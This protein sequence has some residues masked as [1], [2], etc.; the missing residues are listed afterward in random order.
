[1]SSITVATATAKTDAAAAP[2]VVSTT[3]T[4]AT[5]KWTNPATT[6]AASFQVWSTT[7]AGL[8]SKQS[9]ADITVAAGGVQTFTLTGL[10][11]GST[12]TVLLKRYEFSGYVA[13]GS[14][15]VSTLTAALQLSAGTNS[16]LAR[17]PSTDASSTFTVRFTGANIETT[18]IP[19][20]TIEAGMRSATLSNIAAGTY[21]ASLIVTESGTDTV[22]DTGSVAISATATAPV[23][24]TN[25]LCSRCLVEWGGNSSS[26]YRLVD[27]RAKVIM[28][29]DTQGPLRA[30][31]ITGL[32]PGTQ[33]TFILQ[34]KSPDG[35]YVD[36][37]TASLTTA[38]STLTVG[39][40][41]STG[42]KIEW[43]AAYSGA[44]YQL[45]YRSDSGAA[46]TRTLSSLSYTLTGLAPNTLY[47]VSLGVV[48]DGAAVAVAR[49]PLGTLEAAGGNGGAAASSTG[50]VGSS[51]SSSGSSGGVNIPANLLIYLLLA[52]CAAFILIGGGALLLHRKKKA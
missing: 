50:V 23:A 20:S 34:E 32:T 4:T 8:S 1:M 46:T 45:S 52:V 21:Y 15:Q 35:T 13:Q 10:L 36:G 51:S 47:T 42:A 29:P 41:A 22:L 7:S 30:T 24:I 17:W 39:S 27:R 5:V 16:A 26:T 14:V 9:I 25:V 31:P 28:I 48:E 37:T 11:P 12:Y 33:Y 3:Y 6:D 19:A 49:A 2:V 44:S 38:T 18:D 40:V 43:T